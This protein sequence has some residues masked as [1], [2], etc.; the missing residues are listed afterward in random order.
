MG[1]DEALERLKGVLAESCLLVE[2]NKVWS[3]Y[4]DAYE[5]EAAEIRARMA[6]EENEEDEDDDDDDNDE[7]EAADAAS[8]LHPHTSS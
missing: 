8:D 4:Q 3:K 5:A 6:L 7:A 2:W 1:E